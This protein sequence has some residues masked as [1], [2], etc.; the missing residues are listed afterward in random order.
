MTPDSAEHTLRTG[1]RG[2]D[3][4][5]F[6]QRLLAGRLA[7]QRCDACG[8][9]RF[10]P[11]PGC[12]ACGAEAVSWIEPAGPA[13]VVAWTV[14]HATV[15][16][17]LPRKLRSWTPYI[18]VMVRYADVA[19]ALLPALLDSAAFDADLEGAEVTIDGGAPGAPR[20][21]ARLV[22]A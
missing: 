6:W 8:H 15:G 14:T 11:G 3:V 17:R 12:P 18:L 20:L 1:R 21:T 16:E 5:Q 7:L 9:V 4:D 22:S 19:G 2:A 13:R 10:P